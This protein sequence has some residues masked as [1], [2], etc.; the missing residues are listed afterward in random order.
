MDPCIAGKQVLENIIKDVENP[1]AVQ[2]RMREL[3]QIH[4][5]TCCTML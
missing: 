5:E 1:A 4:R 2:E 3:S